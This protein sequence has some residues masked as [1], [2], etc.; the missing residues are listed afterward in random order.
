MM[1]RTA[2]M[3]IAEVF[4]CG[5][6]LWWG[7]VIFSTEVSLVDHEA[8]TQLKPVLWLLFFNA[9]F[10]I[11]TALLALV[12]IFV[13]LFESLRIVNKERVPLL[14]SAT[15][16]QHQR[17]YSSSSANSLMSSVDSLSSSGSRHT[18]TSAASFKSV[19]PHHNKRRRRYKTGAGTQLCQLLRI[20]LMMPSAV[21]VIYCSLT[22]WFNSCQ[23]HDSLYNRINFYLAFYWIFTLIQLIVFS[24]AWGLLGVLGLTCCSVRRKPQLNRRGPI[25]SRHMS[26]HQMTRAHDRSAVTYHAME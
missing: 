18:T 23:M 26:F 15:T 11:L 4:M 1:Q 25:P 5:S 20:F 10:D 6:V 9:L 21:I 2:R 13:A 16:G 3:R 7:V 22:L 14:Q 17:H 19:L 24:W 8:C 12:E